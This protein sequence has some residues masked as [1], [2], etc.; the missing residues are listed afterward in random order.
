MDHCFQKKHFNSPTF[1]HYCSSFLWGIGKQGYQCKRCGYIVHGKCRHLVHVACTCPSALSSQ[2]PLLKETFATTNHRP[3][4]LPQLGST[5]QEAPARPST[6]AASSSAKPH[7]G[8]V[9]NVVE[10]SKVAESVLARDV[11]PVNKSAV[12]NGSS[13][14]L[15]SP[16]PYGFQSATSCVVQDFQ[17]GRSRN[18]TSSEVVITSQRTLHSKPLQPEALMAPLG[19]TAC[20]GFPPKAHVWTNRRSVLSRLVRPSNISLC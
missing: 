2:S 13:Q 19:N 3:A 11:Q 5:A 10:R 9:E 7:V 6:P 8:D 14:L 17:S 18:C 15:P 12:A 1:C 20:F 16:I 4:S